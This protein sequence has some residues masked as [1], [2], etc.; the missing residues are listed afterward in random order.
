MQY[1]GLKD[2]NG[3]EIYK[4]D[5]VKIPDDWDEYG[6]MSGEI[7]Q[8]YFKNGGFRLM[9][10]TDKGDGYWLEYPLSCEVIGNIHEDSNLLK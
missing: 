8:V 3:K 6:F 5:V 9:P 2:K 1:T 4:G 10:K 7:R